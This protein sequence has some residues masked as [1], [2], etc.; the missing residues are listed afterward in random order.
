MEKNPLILIDCRNLPANL[1]AGTNSLLSNQKVIMNGITYRLP[2]IKID[3]KMLFIQEIK[4][5]TIP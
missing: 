3:I 4:N 2:D 5:P 1:L